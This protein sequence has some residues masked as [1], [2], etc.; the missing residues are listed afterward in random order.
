MTVSVDIEVARRAKGLVVALE[1]IHDSAGAEPWVMKI[2]D[3]RAKHQAV[4]LGLRVGG[5]V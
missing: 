3:G 1:A 2:T 4:K 5:K